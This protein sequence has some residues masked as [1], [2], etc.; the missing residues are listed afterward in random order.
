MIVDLKTGRNDPTSDDAVLDHAQ[1]GAY[2]LA[3]ASAAIEGVPDGLINGGAKLVIVSKGRRGTEYAA[4][5]QRAFTASELD[6]FRDRIMI[7][8]DGM[9]GAVFVAQLGSHCLDPW[10]YGRCRIHIVPAVSS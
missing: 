3:F 9:A 4:P 6:A 5:H 8:A 1:L 10:S 2:Q 7:D